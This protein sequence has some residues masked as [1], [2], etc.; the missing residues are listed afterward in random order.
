MNRFH[1]DSRDAV[2]RD[3]ASRLFQILILLGLVLLPILL[4]GCGCRAKVRRSADTA[5]AELRDMEAGLEGFYADFG[6]Y[7][8]PALAGWEPARD[9][10]PAVG[11]TPIALTAPI[12]Y[13]RS[14]P[15]DPFR[16]VPPNTNRPET[17]AYRYASDPLACWILASDG[18][19]RDVDVDLFAYVDPDDCQCDPRIFLERYGHLLYD[20]F[21]GTD[22]NGDIVRMGP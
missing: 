12:P 2:R 16:S 18:P 17:F 10:A 15:D 1:S 8:L 20:P 4:A 9:F 11:Y 3:I 7:P 5:R 21:N 6:H 22:S 19:D 13:L 14:L